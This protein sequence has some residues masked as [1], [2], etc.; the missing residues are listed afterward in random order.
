MNA[1]QYDCLVVASS[2]ATADLVLGSLDP[3]FA[4]QR[5]ACLLLGTDAAAVAAYGPGLAVASIEIAPE[6]SPHAPPELLGSVLISKVR[7]YGSVLFDSSQGARDLS[8]WLAVRLDARVATTV[9]QV[10]VDE[11]A[12]TL[13][14]LVNGGTARV[15]QRFAYGPPQIVA[16]TRTVEPLSATAS[17]HTPA[18]ITSELSASADE[19]SIQAPTDDSKLTGARIVVAVGRG[20]GGPEQLRLFGELAR[21]LGAALGATRVVVDKGW[22]PFAHQI[23]QTGAVVSPDLYLGFGV[24]GAPQHLAGIRESRCLVA[25]NTDRSAP[26]CDI[27]DIVVQADAVQVAT[28]VLRGIKERCH[29]RM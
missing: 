13:T 17:S 22:L 23:G 8:G 7:D 5:T 29:E 18:P 2:P 10:D 1:S 27:A 9:Q 21:V 3:G 28:Q 15:R 14:R 12:L 19:V 4:A 26:L 25:V 16:L 6:V 20:I 24:S 11:S